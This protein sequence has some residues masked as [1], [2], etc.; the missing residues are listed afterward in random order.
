MLNSFVFPEMNIQVY[1]SQVS[2][3]KQGLHTNIFFQTFQSFISS[4]FMLENRAFSQNLLL[5]MTAASMLLV[6]HRQWVIPGKYKRQTENI[7]L[8]FVQEIL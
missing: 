4:I 7:Y 1:S 2:L 5:K 6:P 3:G 8:L